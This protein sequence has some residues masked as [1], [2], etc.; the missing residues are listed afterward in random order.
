MEE[1]GDLLPG[2]YIAS[3]D[4]MEEIVG[5]KVDMETIQGGEAGGP[6]QQSV[7]RGGADS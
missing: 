5:R 3:S 2:A 7:W 4:I 6:H 1:G